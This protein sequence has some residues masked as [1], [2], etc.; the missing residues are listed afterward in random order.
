MAR[1]CCTLVVALLLTGCAAGSVTSKET[2][3]EPTVYATVNAPPNPLLVGCHMRPAPP[4]YH[5]PNSY[6]YCLV[7]KGER[8]AVYFHW[9]NGKTKAEHKGWEPFT[10]NG[11]RLQSETDPSVFFVK[12]GEVW[13]EVS[14]A[15]KAHRMIPY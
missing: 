6:S 12:N 5:H 13:H 10:I 9:R 7:R 15:G 11:D 14:G 4:E 1:L 3:G 8:Y 2:A